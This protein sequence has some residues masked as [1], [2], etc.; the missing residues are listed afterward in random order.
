MSVQYSMEESSQ[1]P[2][3][4]Q[5]VS[6]GYFQ[7]SSAWRE[8]SSYWYGIVWTQI[9][10]NS[11]NSRSVMDSCALYFRSSLHISCTYLSFTVK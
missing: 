6:A 8:T 1:S 2:P 9:I 11:A 3:P 7:Y 4:S 5:N 10:T